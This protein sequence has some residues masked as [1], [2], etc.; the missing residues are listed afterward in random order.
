MT[1]V[2]YL[3]VSGKG[4]LAGDGFRRQLETVTAFCRSRG[5]QLQGVYREEAV[6]GKSDRDDRPAFE[7]MIS[8]ILAGDCRTIVVESLDRLAREWRVQQQFLMYIAVKGVTLF[9]ANTGENVTEALLADP[10]RK[11]MVHM[12]AVFAEW[13][14]DM[15]VK[16]LAR[17]RGAKRKAN[18]KCEGP[19]CFGRD[20]ER[21]EEH[22]TLQV[23]LK[24]ASEGMNGHDITRHLNENGYR[25]RKSQRWHQ[26]SV[27][28]IIR[29]EAFGNCNY[30]SFLV[31]E[32]KEKV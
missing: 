13:D 24:L 21:L 19:P 16:R 25:P 29:R 3:R 30:R 8:E 5:F 22:D 20:P 10:T 31:L 4:Q 17:A 14:K 1:A 2:A 6:P 23:M 26:V 7:H 27:D 9:S 11:A 18:G 28:R 12:Q 15:I 32:D